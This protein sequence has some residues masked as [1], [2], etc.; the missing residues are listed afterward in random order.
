MLDIEKNGAWGVQDRRWRWATHTAQESN[1]NRANWL[2]IW[3]LKFLFYR[4]SRARS[5]PTHHLLALSI[6]LCVNVSKWLPMHAHAQTQTKK[7]ST[8]FPP[9]LSLHTRWH[10]LIEDTKILSENLESNVTL[11][12]DFGRR[13][14]RLQG[15]TTTR[16]ECISTIIKRM[17]FRGTH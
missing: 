10:L 3:N 9:S 13:M 2:W 1:N 14:T 17:T 8:V 7:T 4:W 6:C 15:K 5:P 12:Y 16:K 11:S